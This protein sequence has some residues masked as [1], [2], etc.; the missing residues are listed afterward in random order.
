MK[1]TLKKT[2]AL[3]MVL[4]MLSALLPMEVFAGSAGAGPAA[5]FEDET[6]EEA[7]PEAPAGEEPAPEEE[8]LPDRSFHTVLR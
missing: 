1:R 3:L 6:N 7:V 2:V 8:A 5:V 4:V